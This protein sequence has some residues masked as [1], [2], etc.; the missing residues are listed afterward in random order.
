MKSEQQKAVF[1]FECTKPCLDW[2]DIVNVEIKR[3]DYCY[4]RIERRYDNT[5]LL[6]GM[7]PPAKRGDYNWLTKTLGR[8]SNRDL[9]RFIEWAKEG[10]GSKIIEVSSISG[11]FDIL[12]DIAELLRSE[13]A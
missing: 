8:I 5:W 7:N 11:S 1:C 6:V 10:R 13:N 12:H 2:Y 4:F 3:D 9:V